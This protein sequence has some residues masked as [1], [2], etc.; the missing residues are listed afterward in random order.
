[1]QASAFASSFLIGTRMSTE[2]G[3]ALAPFKPT[4][5]IDITFKSVITSAKVQSQNSIIYL[6]KS[7]FP[8]STT[9]I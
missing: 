7:G 4:T 8:K 1:M 2:A 6:S 5:R 9:N 3:T